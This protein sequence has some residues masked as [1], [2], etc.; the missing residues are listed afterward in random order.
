M[1]SGAAFVQDGDLRDRA[2]LGEQRAPSLVVAQV[3]LS[4]PLP[5]A[6]LQFCLDLHKRTNTSRTSA[7]D[8]YIGVFKVFFSAGQFRHDEP[9][10]G[11]GNCGKVLPKRRTVLL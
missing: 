10:G 6:F 8:L 3:A 7:H 2:A 1:I 4:L 5:E 11:G 9:I